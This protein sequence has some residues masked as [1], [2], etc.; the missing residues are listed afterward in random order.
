MNNIVDFIFSRDFVT[1]EKILLDEVE[2]EPCDSELWV[3]L[4][5]TELQ[6]PFE[7]E[8]LCI[9]YLERAISCD[10]NC[11]NAI[12]IKLYCQ[13][14]S[15]LCMEKKDLFRILNFKFVTPA[16]EAIASYIQ[17]WNYSVY[18][19]DCNL[20]LEKKYLKKSLS[21]FSNTVHPYKR[22]AQ[23]YNESRDVSKAKKY[24]RLALSNVNKVL[25]TDSCYDYI[26]SQF[27]ID[28]YITGVGLSDVN[29]KHLK[30]LA[31]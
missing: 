13:N 6:F 7:D 22:L 4:A 16:Q 2:K 17:S 23:I 27:F 20:S 15:C 11:F 25:T 29:Y 5:L 21:I 31:E 12:A 26:D 8:S 24:Y 19:N 14:H 28:E 3:R 30:L 9:E 10:P 1:V 18:H